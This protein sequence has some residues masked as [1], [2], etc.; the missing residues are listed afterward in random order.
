MSST[1]AER[2]F[3]RAVEEEL[4]DSGW[5][6]KSEA[7]DRARRHRIDILAFHR[8]IECWIGIELK[9]PED[10]R[11]Y[12]SCLAQ[13]IAY[14][15][16]DFHPNPRLLCLLSAERV[17]WFH[18][19]YFWR[20]GFGLGDHTLGDRFNLDVLFP[21]NGDVKTTLN[22]RDPGWRKRYEALSGLHPDCWKGL[23]PK[24]QVEEIHKI[25]RERWR[26]FE[27]QYKC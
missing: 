27:Y 23:D 4:T 21:P 24:Q 9:V 14:R 12:T 22:L 26:T 11:D 20:F 1:I 6:I 5:I 10:N 16:A 3:H 18:Y 19:R 17:E 25:C 15:K 8:L 13:L 7:F 2:D